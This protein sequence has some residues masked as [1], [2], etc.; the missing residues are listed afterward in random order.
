MG[1][2]GNVYQG[3]L[4]DGKI[5]AIKCASLRSAQGHKEFQNEL[6][7]LARLH[8]RN[9]VGLLGFCD[10]GG[11]QILVYEYMSNGDL[12]DNLFGTDGRPSLNSYQRVEVAL[13]IARG[14]DYLHSFADPPVIHRDIKASNI[15]LD[16]FMV[17]KLAD[18][19]VSKISPEP[20]SHISTRPVG[21]M[22]Y[23]D[24]E[25]FRTNQVTVSSDIYSF[26]IVLLEIITGKPIIDDQR[27]ENTNLEDWVKPRFILRGV[28]E[29]VDPKFKGDYDEELF[30]KMTELAIRCTSAKRNDR[31][32]MKEV[33]NILEPL[34]R[35]SLEA[36]SERMHSVSKSIDKSL[37]SERS[38]FYFNYESKNPPLVRESPE[39]GESSSDGNVVTKYLDNLAT[40]QQVPR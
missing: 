23:V 2:F 20:Y 38:E 11:L 19:G 36:L 25:Y 22:G 26:G 29:I 21:T 37:S 13:G 15:L 40:I 24:P 1:G 16:E 34:A 33:L 5:V 14:L 35:A 28:K 4:N 17:A 30:T 27:G 10:D 8:H 9:L 7:L 18:F 31:P 3:F 39:A 6:T 32:T 12:Y